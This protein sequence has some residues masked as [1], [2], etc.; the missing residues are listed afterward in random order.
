MK[1]TFKLSISFCLF[2]L[3]CLYAQDN[4]DCESFL[5]Q[6]DEL[7]SSEEKLKKTTFYLEQTQD[8][9]CQF[10]LWKKRADIFERKFLID[11]VS[12]SLSKATHIAESLSEDE[13]YL[14]VALSNVYFYVR[15]NKN[16]QA[17]EV[18]NLCRKKL[19]KNLKSKYWLN[20][21]NR[22][23]YVK[24]GERDYKSA[25]KF[26]DSG[27][28]L[29]EK[30]KHTELLHK[31][32][33]EK[34]SYHIRLSQY[35]EAIISVQKAISII[36]KLDS[37]KRLGFAYFLKG[38]CY[39]RLRDFGQTVEALEASITTASKYNDLE[40]LARSYSRLSISLGHLKENDRALE[41][42][43]STI[44]ISKRTGDYSGLA[45]GYSDKG[46]ILLNNIEDYKEAEKAFLR[47]N[48]IF[49]TEEVSQRTKDITSVTN[50]GG[51][52]MLSEKKKDYAKMLRYLKQYE[53]GVDNLNLLVNKK[54][55]ARFYMQYNE[56]IGD[57]KKALKYQRKATK[58]ADSIA[59]KQVRV[60][61]AD[62]EKK[63]ET[64][65]KE[66]EVLKLNEESQ[67]QKIRTQKAETKQLIYLGIALFCVL[68]LLISV[69]AYIKIRKQQKALTFAHKQLKESH[70]EV[71]STNR[72][73][74]RL[75]S[76]ISHDMRNM[77]IPF[78]RGGKILKYYIDKKEYE[79]VTELSHKLQ[80]NSLN[81]SNL[82]DNLLNW[83]LEQ[84]NGYTIKVE[85]IMITE[86]L[87]E[88]K[89]AFLPYAKEKNTAINIVGG[90][91]IT[92]VFDKGAFHI[93]F[94]NLIGNA[95]KYTENG[96]ITIKFSEQDETIMYEVLDTGIGMSQDQLD[97]LFKLKKNKTEGT[98]GEKGT[99][100]GLNLVYRFVE[101]NKGNIKV[102]S[103]MNIGSKFE[104][105]FPKV[106][107]TD[108]STSET[109]INLSV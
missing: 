73:K 97:N 9:N 39:E 13:L 57:F 48:T 54:T 53:D 3:F 66:I 29:G 4:S 11:S 82:L 20:Y 85:S 102:S 14:E 56:G 34:V 26:V 25:I 78:Q 101:L 30:F 55:L 58:I 91:E 44:S 70:E 28:Q 37:K 103:E 74:D 22:W 18:L 12:Y 52:V 61:V 38:V 23:A 6:I 108:E 46:F 84:M 63:Y 64:Q 1:K 21:Y 15:A 104:L 41:V 7:G 96:T 99:G 87:K 27:I 47:S 94:R 95:L 93:I 75:F 89:N 32:Y 68:L 90:S 81:L 107:I 59:N 50:L 62:L 83:S 49:E 36:E 16:K 98:K 40:T 109:T 72:V 2:T 45:L 42:L 8:L 106:I 51:L 71:A 92:G 79:K 35:K 31:I 5:E 43:D 77:L 80:E 33:L 86:E 76:V 24:D 88:I 105:H 19:N 17:I 65:K 100:I 60:D 69:W 10:Q 67:K